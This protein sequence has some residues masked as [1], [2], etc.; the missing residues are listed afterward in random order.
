M[1]AYS[2][3]RLGPDSS[4]LG[5]VHSKASSL[6]ADLEHSLKEAVYNLLSG[7]RDNDDQGVDDLMQELDHLFVHV[8][9]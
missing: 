5:T 3:L 2:L 1:P 6:R 4:V 9:S 7:V 8:Q